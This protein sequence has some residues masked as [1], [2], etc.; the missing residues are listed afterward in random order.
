MKSNS[1]KRVQVRREF[2]RMLA[3]RDSA[4]RGTQPLPPA[5]SSIRV[6]VKAV[7]EALGILRDAGR[8][9]ALDDRMV[10]VREIYRL[11]GVE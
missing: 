3:T 8:A 6:G 9:A 7:R 10:P 4:D 2:R 1:S 11:Q 5:S